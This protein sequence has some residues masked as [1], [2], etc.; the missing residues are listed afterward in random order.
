MVSAN[1]DSQTD[2]SSHFSSYAQPS[3]DLLV[4]PG[5]DYKVLHHL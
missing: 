3:Y 4:R 1:G 2:L 5:Y